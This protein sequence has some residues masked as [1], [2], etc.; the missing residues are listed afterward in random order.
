MEDKMFRAVLAAYTAAA[1]LVGFASVSQAGQSQYDE[2]LVIV[3]GNTHH[4]IYDDG[5]DDLF[6]VTR[7]FVVG[8]NDYGRPIFRRTIHCR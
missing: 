4:V 1:L 6:C 5:Y 8:Y 3:N 2:R 7:R